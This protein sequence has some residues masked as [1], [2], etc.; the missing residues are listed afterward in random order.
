MEKIIVEAYHNVLE[1]EET[2]GREHSCRKGELEL[3]WGHIAGHE[4]RWTWI[5]TVK[6]K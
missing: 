6:F 3:D 1:Q 5:C 4:Q 2:K